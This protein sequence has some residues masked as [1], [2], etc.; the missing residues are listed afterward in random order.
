LDSDEDVV[1]GRVGAGA[2]NA[3]SALGFHLI[4]A[5]S[6]NSNKKV[7]KV[8]SDLESHERFVSAVERS[9]PSVAVTSSSS[10]IVSSNGNLSSSVLNDSS[11][12]SVSV[13]S[14]ESSVALD[15]R[16]SAI[17]QNF[18]NNGSVQIHLHF[19]GKD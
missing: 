13:H 16:V 3:G 14:S 17:L 5:A 10:E 15:P 2:L 12:S 11:N 6:S 8:L 7:E 1:V 19:H 9:S 4:G 18:Q